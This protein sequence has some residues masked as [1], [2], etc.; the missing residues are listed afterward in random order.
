MM[1]LRV[2]KKIFN[3]VSR[4][5][6]RLLSQ[7]QSL[8]NGCKTYEDRQ[9]LLRALHNVAVGSCGYDSLRVSCSLE[10][11]QRTLRNQVRKKFGGR[12]SANLMWGRYPETRTVVAWY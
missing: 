10:R 6:T 9:C 3:K 4:E 11:L 5:E 8:I 2:A 12:V 7:F 1:P